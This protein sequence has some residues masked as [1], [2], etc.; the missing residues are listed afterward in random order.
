MAK[1]LNYSNTLGAISTSPTISIS[2]VGAFGGEL[3]TL[4]GT[5]QQSGKGNFSLTFEYLPESLTF[6]TSNDLK[7]IPLAMTNSQLLVATHGRI[8]DIQ[9]SVKVVAGCNGAICS[10]AKNTVKSN[11]TVIQ[12]T[13]KVAETR[14]DLV[15]IAKMMYSLTLFS[16]T[17]KPPPYCNLVIGPFCGCTGAFSAVSINYN[18]PYDLDGC[19][20]DMEI[21]FTFMPSEYG[22]L[23]D[24]PKQGDTPATGGLTM[25][26]DSLVT[27]AQTYAVY[28]GSTPAVAP[29]PPDPGLSVTKNPVQSFTGFLGDIFNTLT[30]HFTN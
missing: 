15:T 20:T 6:S 9:V 17:G 25:T 5:K 3:S 24:D 14:A 10:F 30:D 4:A 26:S 13:A 23:T 8:D 28:V 11:Y 27:G 16:S 18:G 19:P 22:L 21:S 29:A 1:V 7:A 12:A 2:T